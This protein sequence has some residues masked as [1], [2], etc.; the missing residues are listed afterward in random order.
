MFQKNFMALAL[1]I[2]TGCTGLQAVDERGRTVRR[3]FGYLEVIDPPTT[4]LPPDA[5]VRGGRVY[6]VKVENGVTLGYSETSVVRVPFD[7][8]AVILV[9]THEQLDQIEQLLNGIAKEGDICGA[10]TPN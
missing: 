10:V 5:E 8:R 3:Y 4:N 6:G 2:L 9:K 7:C 1:V